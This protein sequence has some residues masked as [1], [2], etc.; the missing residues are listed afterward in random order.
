MDEVAVSPERV[1]LNQRVGKELNYIDKN[2]ASCMPVYMWYIPVVAYR[3]QLSMT[4][5]TLVSSGSSF[6]LASGNEE[7]ER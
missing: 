5:A 1:V 4:E 3:G 6:G 7:I 2:C